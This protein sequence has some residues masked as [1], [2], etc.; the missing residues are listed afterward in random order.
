MPSRTPAPIEAIASESA[1]GY[2]EPFRSRMG[3]A[4]WRALGDHFGLTQFGVSLETL[5]PGAQSSLRHWHSLTDEFVVM[6][7]GELALQTDDGEFILGPGMCMGFKAGDR[8]A[9]HLINKSGAVASFLVVGSRVPGDLAFY[10]DDDLATL[11]TAQGRAAVH[12]DGQPSA[13]PAGE[14]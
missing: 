8:N 6:R 9:H 11:V 10:P 14:A 3:Q 7:S 4:S 13:P 12:K 2:P 5:A 1:V